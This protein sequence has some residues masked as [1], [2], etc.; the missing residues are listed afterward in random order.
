L[1]P[2]DSLE[3]KIRFGC[4]FVFGFVITG[5]SGIV[6]IVANGHYVA[7]IALLSGLG[8]GV[9]AMRYGDRF[10]GTLAKLKIWWYGWF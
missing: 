5:L 2:P 3:K 10:W 6:W 8:C 7:A 1:E 9:C 4:G